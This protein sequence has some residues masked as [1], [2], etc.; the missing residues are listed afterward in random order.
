MTTTT[1]TSKATTTTTPSTTGSLMAIGGFDGFGNNLRSVELL[2]TSCDFP[3]PEGRYG[4]ISVTTT[5]GKILVCGGYT[6][7]GSTASCLE[8][9]F[10]TK[11]WEHHS[12]MKSKRYKASAIALKNGVI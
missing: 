8:F 5:D 9:N 11:T 12:N 4:H 10:K 1:S 6:S 7:S 2:P 3:L